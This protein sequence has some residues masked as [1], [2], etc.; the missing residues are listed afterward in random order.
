MN[1]LDKLIKDALQEEDSEVL[2]A[3]ESQPSVLEMV[4]ETFRGRYRWLAGLAIAW[5]VVFMGMGIYAGVRFFA[6]EQLRDIVLWAGACA[7][8]LAAV[9]M[10][11]I[12]YWMELNKNALTREIKRLE[13][14]VARLASRHDA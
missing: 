1:D 14:Q 3:L 4:G 8:S 11:K 9:S 13:L 7:L 10:I 2:R 12:W 5:S 6:A